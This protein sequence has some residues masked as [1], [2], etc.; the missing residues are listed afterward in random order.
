MFKATI[1]DRYLLIDSI[2]TIAELI[3]EGVFKIS[4]D[5]ISLIAADRAMVAVVDFKLDASA[6]DSFE[7]DKEQSIGINV[8]NFLSILKRASGEDKITL[9]LEDSSKLEITLKNSSRRRFLLPLIDL[10]QEEVPPIEQLEFSATVE[11]KSEVLESGIEDA[12]LVSDALLFEASG[13]KFVMRAEGDVSRTELELERGEDP[14]IDLKA[15]G[16]IK[17]RYPL[18][19]LKKMIKAAKLADTVK[20]YF[21][22]D[23]PMK[24]EFKSGDKVSLVFVVAPRV[25]EE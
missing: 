23:Y 24:L 5:G 6:F 1:S 25:S 22:Q 17:A 21:G 13:N 15:N 18:D 3:D 16:S 10:T 11:L 7:V 2:S 8:S 12:E 4:K 14:L 19:Y 9:S 20:I